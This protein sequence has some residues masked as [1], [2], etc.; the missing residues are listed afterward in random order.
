VVGEGDSARDAGRFTLDD[1]T[2]TI[3]LIDGVR[4]NDL[5]ADA[6]A[7]LGRRLYARLYRKP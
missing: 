6:V 3:R 5:D 4:S 1:K 2:A 7:A